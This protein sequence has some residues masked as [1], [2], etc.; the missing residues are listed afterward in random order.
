MKRK[1]EFAKIPLHIDPKI[2][3]PRHYSY[4]ELLE[5]INS[6]IE[7]FSEIERLK[8]ISH[9]SNDQVLVEPETT[10]NK[11]NEDLREVWL[12][13]GFPIL[14]NEKTLIM[15]GARHAFCLHTYQNQH[16]SPN[17]CFNFRAR[18]LIICG[19]IMNQSR[20]KPFVFPF[21]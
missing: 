13:N 5:K 9:Q 15:H 4:K 18:L 20:S 3:K 21:V 11:L 17:L 2:M 7:H 12:K 8:T 6:L 10:A 1:N 16:T 19:I 14:K